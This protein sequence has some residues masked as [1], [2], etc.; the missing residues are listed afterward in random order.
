[1]RYKPKNIA[2]LHIALGGLPDRM[3]VETERGLGVSAKSVGDLRKLTTWP[4]NLVITTPQ[5]RHPE[6]VVKISKAGIA[7]HWLTKREPRVKEANR[8]LKFTAA[9]Q[10]QKKDRGQA[11]PAGSPCYSDTTEPHLS[12]AALPKMGYVL[13]V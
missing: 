12:Q 6:S 2:A 3:R 8:A 13:A 9:E 4:E 1:M 5:E 7:T 10:T 11:Q